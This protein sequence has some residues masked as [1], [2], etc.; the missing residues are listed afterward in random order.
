MYV[1]QFGSLN[2]E[3]SL[4]DFFIVFVGIVS[5]WMLMYFMRRLPRMRTVMFIPFVV[6]LPFGYIGTLG[7][8]LLGVIGILL[9][10]LVPFAVILSIGY[11]LIKHFATRTSATRMTSSVGNGHM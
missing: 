11:W 8:G 2:T 10:G 3:F 9:G 6:A 7:G 4:P 1:I 5:V